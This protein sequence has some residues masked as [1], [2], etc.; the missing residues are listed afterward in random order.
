[1]AQHCLSLLLLTICIFRH[2]PQFSIWNRLFIML[3]VVGF[4]WLC[5]YT[6]PAIKGSPCHSLVCGST[7]FIRWPYTMCRYN[8]MFIQVQYV[9]VSKHPLWG[10]ARFLVYRIRTMYNGRTN[11]IYIHNGHAN[12]M[13]VCTMYKTPVIPTQHSL[14]TSSWVRTKQKHTH[15]SLN[16]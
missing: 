3:N 11:Y 13:T 14:P 10:L 9:L 12:V 1:M 4:V 6:A 5:K 16:C 15:G 2:E 7:D 8:H